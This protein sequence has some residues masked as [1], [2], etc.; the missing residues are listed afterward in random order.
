ME[1]YFFRI[2]RAVPSFSTAQEPHFQIPYR[3]VFSSMGNRSTSI[4]CVQFYFYT[5]KSNISVLTIGFPFSIAK[6]NR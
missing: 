6:I 1:Q 4:R 5:V 2:W 3:P